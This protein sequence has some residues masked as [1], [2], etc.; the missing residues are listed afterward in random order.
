LCD[1]SVSGIRRIAARPRGER[2]S[3]PF[4]SILWRPVGPRRRGAPRR[5]KALTDFEP[6][7]RSVLKRSGFLVHDSRVVERRKQ[8]KAKTG[9]RSRSG[10]AGRYS[11]FCERSEASRGLRPPL[12]LL[13]RPA[14][15]P[16]FETPQERAPENQGPCRVHARPHQNRKPGSSL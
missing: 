7:P 3:K 14:R 15:P 12:Q 5:S 13:L 4:A 9:A 16:G 11:K 8:G 6:E 2:G 1:L 10:I